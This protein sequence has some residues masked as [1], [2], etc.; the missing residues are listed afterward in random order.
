MK[1]EDG[2]LVAENDE[3]TTALKEMTE[4]SVKGLKSKNS[5]LIGKLKTFDAYKDIDPDEY[6]TLKD[7]AAKA[8]EERALKAGEFDSVKKQ[9]L[10]AH[11]KEKT[12]WEE[13]KT[14]LRKSLEDNV[15]IATATQAIAAEKGSSLL[16]MPH[17]RTRTKLD[18]TGRPVVIDED[19]QVRVGADGKPLAIAQLVAEMKAD[20]DTFGRAFDASGANGGGTPPPGTPPNKQQKTMT[21]AQFDDSDTGTKMEFSKAGGKVVD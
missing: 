5:E 21:R 7:S 8:E 14:T 11:A 10:D 17:V 1:I 9:L 20:V 15:L 18:E 13:E 4:E 3:E 19:G 16:L 2:K 12:T 6:R